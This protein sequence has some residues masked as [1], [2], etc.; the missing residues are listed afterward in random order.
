ME[1]PWI[2]PLFYFHKWE[3]LLSF[4]LA[5]FIGAVHAFVKGRSKVNRKVAQLSFPDRTSCHRPSRS[6]V[7]GG[8]CPQARC[9]GRRPWLPRLEED[10]CSDEWRRTSGALPVVFSRINRS[11]LLPGR[12]ALR[13]K[14]FSALI[15]KEKW[16]TPL[17]PGLLCLIDAPGLVFTPAPSSGRGFNVNTGRLSR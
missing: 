13:L 9:R 3:T 10:A 4:L 6:S 5:L 16:K 7:V 15:W 11:G 1:C 12:Q 17:I 8:L 14:C 2:Y